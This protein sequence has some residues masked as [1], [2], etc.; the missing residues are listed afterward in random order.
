[1][2]NNKIFFFLISVLFTTCNSFN[3][4]NKTPERLSNIPKEAVWKGGEDGGFWFLNVSQAKD[5]N[6]IRLKVFNDYDGELIL[7]AD[8]KIPENCEV[9]TNSIVDNIN[10]FD[11][12]K[13]VLVNDCKLLIKH[14][15]HKKKQV[16]FQIRFREINVTN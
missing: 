10:Y 16:M 9:P 8:F 3:Q 6:I 5:K 13:I 2:R 12:E 15:Y 14:P 1:M 11:F 4:K 7:D